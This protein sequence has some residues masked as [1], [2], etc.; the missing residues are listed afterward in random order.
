MNPRTSLPQILGTLRLSLHVVFA[1]LLAFA[2]VRTIA[3]TA[4]TAGM[5]GMSGARLT[6]A[7]VAG[8]ALGGMYLLGAVA[9]GRAHWWLLGLLVV[10]TGMTAATH[11]AVWLLF[12]L[13]F[14]ILTVLAGRAASAAVLALAWAVA[15][16]VPTLTG[17]G[18]GVA[19]AVGP[20]IGVLFAAAAYWAYQALAREAEHQRELAEQL[21]RTRDRLLIAEKQA[22]R[23]AERES[24][25]RDI[26]DTLAQ[27]FNSV[28]L[29]SRAASTALRQGRP[30]DAATQLQVIET[31]ARDN[32]G[33]SRDLVRGLLD[34]EV[35]E[36]VTAALQHLIDDTV[37]RQ[38]ALGHELEIGLSADGVG[39]G[40]LPPTVHGAVVRVVREALTNIVR[41]AGAT[42]AHVTLG[43][44]PDE[45]TVDVFDDG[46]GFDPD[47]VG[48]TAG[49]GYGLAGMRASVEE[50]G[51]RFEVVTEGGT[52]VNASVPVPPVEVGQG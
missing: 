2:L 41:H 10:W 31:T 33:Q 18:G 43:V 22:G 46:R 12:P 49:G 32:L 36:P 37:T 42:R 52:V 17:Q 13:S 28:V 23:L 20:G 6:L 8:A 1:A 4:G 9:Q 14:V 30:D 26:H 15:A 5:S 21:L 40:T 48:R 44:W 50:L 16:F 47:Q 11:H 25:S 24:I 34:G 38:R 19:G 45:V 35:S 29:L 3:E 7:V 27:G 51:G 39:T